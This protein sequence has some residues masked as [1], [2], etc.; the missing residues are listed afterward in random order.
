MKFIYLDLSSYLLNGHGVIKLYRKDGILWLFMSD[1][2]MWNH[3]HGIFVL[4]VSR[5]RSKMI[6]GTTLSTQ[7][8]V[9]LFAAPNT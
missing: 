1:I 4:D 3:F 9:Y 7:K 5:W 8:R 6:L 2:L